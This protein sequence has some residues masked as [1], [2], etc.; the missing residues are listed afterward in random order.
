MRR[1]FGR[2]RRS[3]SENGGG[4][5]GAP[6]DPAQAIAQVLAARAVDAERLEPIPLD[7][8]PATFAALGVGENAAGR[9]VAVGFSPTRG[10]D[11]ALAVLALG[12]RR[13]AASEPE[14]NLFAVAPDWSGADRRRLA[15][16]SP[17]L[18]LT[19]LAA[20]ALA[21]GGVRIAPEPREP[22]LIE[23]AL[24][25]AG[26]TA[27]AIASRSRARSRASKVSRPSTA[28]CCAADRI[29]RSSCCSRGAR[30]RWSRSRVRYGSRCSTRSA[31]PCRCPRPRASPRLWI[32]SRVCSA[33]S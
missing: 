25:A 17:R 21:P 10:A 26:S 2:G 8:V 13:R 20:S 7:G 28:A 1:R 18:P 5:G 23:P 15:L 6:I 11:A 12:A 31:Q 16:L 29:A 4:R 33:S 24:L 14:A 22:A 32:D 3:D 27:R 19:A 30:R 9:P